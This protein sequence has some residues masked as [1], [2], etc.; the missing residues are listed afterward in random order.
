MSADRHNPL[1]HI[2]L[3]TTALKSAY[4]NTTSLSTGTTAELRKVLIP[5]RPPM[6][7][8]GLLFFAR[9]RGGIAQ[10]VLSRKGSC[11]PGRM[12]AGLRGSGR[13]ERAGTAA[14]SGPPARRWID[15]RGV[16]DLPDGG[17]CDHHAELRQLAVDAAV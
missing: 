6:M 12:I 3:S 15:A 14:R 11:I 9:E 16:Q 4:R 2:A 10:S 1:P 17:R 8:P 7:V 13:P 5:G